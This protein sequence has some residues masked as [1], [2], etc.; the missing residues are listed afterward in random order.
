MN[1]IIIGAI[2]TYSS[3]YIFQYTFNYF[4]G[5]IVNK[6]TTKISNKVYKKIENVV[7]GN[8]EKINA[9]YELIY[10]DNNEE[11]NSNEFIYVN[12]VP[13]PNPIDQNWGSV[14]RL[15]TSS[16]TVPSSSTTPS[17]IS[18]GNDASSVSSSSI[19]LD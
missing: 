13:R 18:E 5:K 8:E 3:P 19:S 10:Y 4:T 12:S 2:L 7:I 1:Q 6:I 17:L 16:S 15:E 14:S 11:Y 9:E